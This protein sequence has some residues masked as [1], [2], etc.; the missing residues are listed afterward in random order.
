MRYALTL[1]LIALPSCSTARANDGDE[2]CA[3]IAITELPPV[4]LAA[5][6]AVSVEIALPKRTIEVYP[7][8]VMRDGVLLFDACSIELEDR[9]I[10]YTD[11]CP[12]G[13]HPLALGVGGL[14]CEE[15]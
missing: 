12:D 15:D 6:P 2:T 13:W 8:K 5:P 1:L 3:A 11:C 10:D 7:G 14:I 9:S 4:E